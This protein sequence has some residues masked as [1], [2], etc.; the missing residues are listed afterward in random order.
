MGAQSQ[1]DCKTIVKV[2]GTHVSL[3][4]VRCVLPEDT[5]AKGEC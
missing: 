5:S 3:P 4:H 2:F 1:S